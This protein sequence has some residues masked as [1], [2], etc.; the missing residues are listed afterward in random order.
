MAF[1]LE[2]YNSSGVATVSV[3]DR[4]ARFHGVYTVSGVTADFS[5]FV[6]VTGYALDGTWFYIAPE[7]AGSGIVVTPAAGGFNV[8]RGHDGPAPIS[9]FK[10]YVWRG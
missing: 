7:A 9:T 10:I 2:V 4:L 3:T 1:G 6:A 5:T 8:S